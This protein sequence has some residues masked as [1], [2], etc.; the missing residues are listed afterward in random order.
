MKWFDSYIDELKE[1]LNLPSDYAA[2]KF[3]GV[4]R[5]SMTKVRNGQVLGKD[6]CLRLAVAV[7]LKRDP[8]E[9]IATAEA[10]TEKNQELKAVWL[11]LAKEKGNS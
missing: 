8:L 9:I 5:Q 11:K 2:A 1:K 4:P 7:A 6:K 3:L 10:Q